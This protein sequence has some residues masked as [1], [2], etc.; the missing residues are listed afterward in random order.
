MVP[1]MQKVQPIAQPTWEETQSVFRPGS[2]MYTDSMSFPSGC[3]R[4]T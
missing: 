3:A 2:G 1:V 4:S